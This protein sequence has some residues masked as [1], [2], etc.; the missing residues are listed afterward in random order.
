MTVQS[1][2]NR[3][4]SKVNPDQLREIYSLINNHFESK[5]SSA[6]EINKIT[7]IKSNSSTEGKVGLV[8][9]A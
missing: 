9:R 6:E 3:R 5:G 4:L 7:G 1:A 8:V 2:L